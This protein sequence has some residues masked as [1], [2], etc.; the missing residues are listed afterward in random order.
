MDEATTRSVYVPVPDKR[1]IDVPP[2]ELFDAMEHSLDVELCQ[3]MD[4]YVLRLLHSRIT[5]RCLIPR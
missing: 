4:R 3:N 5:S 1:S 2:L